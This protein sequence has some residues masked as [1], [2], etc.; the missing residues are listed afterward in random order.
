[1]AQPISNPNIPVQITA[2]EAAALFHSLPPA[3]LENV[4]RIAKV[5]DLLIYPFH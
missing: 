4:T 1:M 2:E 5:G 3:S